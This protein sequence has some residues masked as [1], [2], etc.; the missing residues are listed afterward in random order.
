MMTSI[1]AHWQQSPDR[2]GGMKDEKDP[3]EDLSGEIGRVIADNRK[4]IAKLLQDDF[5]LDEETFEEE[6]SDSEP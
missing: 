5:D 3:I 1:A 6:E 4:F 2:G